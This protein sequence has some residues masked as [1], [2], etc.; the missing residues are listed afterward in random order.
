MYVCVSV[1]LLELSCEYED[2]EDFFGGGTYKYHQNYR[3]DR[4]PYGTHY[5]TAALLKIKVLKN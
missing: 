3:R 1:K 5:Q 2:T 4:M